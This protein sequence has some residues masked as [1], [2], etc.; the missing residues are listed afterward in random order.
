LENTRENIEI[1]TRKALCM[2]DEKSKIEILTQLHGVGV[3]TASAILTVIY[4]EKYGIIDVRCVIALKEL[5]VIKWEKINLDNWIEYL[6]IIRELAN[7]SKRTPREIE[8]ALFA[9]NRI[10][11]DKESKNLYK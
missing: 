9:Y 7:Q 5:D 2:N 11:L 8:M 10:E 6:K 3:P 1:N 4:P